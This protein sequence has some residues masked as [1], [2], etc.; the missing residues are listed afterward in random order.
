[1]FNVKVE[2]HHLVMSL[3]VFPFSR[4]LPSFCGGVPVTKREPFASH[5]GLLFVASLPTMQRCANHVP[6]SRMWETT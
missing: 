5:A 4:T 2:S 3:S 6:P 1:M